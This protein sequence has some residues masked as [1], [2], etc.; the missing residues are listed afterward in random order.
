MARG[1]TDCAF[2][3]QV[4]GVQSPVIQAFL[5]AAFG[6]RI[7]PSMVHETREGLKE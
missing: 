4:C 1:I 6:N 3:A 2:C 7:A 5:H